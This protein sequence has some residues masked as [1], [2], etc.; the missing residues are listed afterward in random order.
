MIYMLKKKKI[1]PFMFLLSDVSKS[2]NLINTTQIIITPIVATNIDNFLCLKTTQIMKFF[3]FIDSNTFWYTHQEYLVSQLADLIV[4]QVQ[5]LRLLRYVD[6]D[7]VQLFILACGPPQRLYHVAL[8][9]IRTLDFL[10]FP[11]GRAQ[12]RPHENQALYAHILGTLPSGEEH[13]YTAVINFVSHDRISR[14]DMS[15]L[16]KGR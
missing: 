10:G 12:Q 11:F 4:G 8:A 1:G 9:V 5:H 6:L 3:H 16:I 7:R 13:F 14:T 15:K 2:L